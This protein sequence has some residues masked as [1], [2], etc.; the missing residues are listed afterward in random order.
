MRNSQEATMRTER[1]RGFM[2]AVAMTIATAAGARA[3]TDVEGS[4]AQTASD[5]PRAVRV[6][7]EGLREHAA[8]PGL[9]IAVDVG[10]RVAFSEAFGVADLETRAPATVGTR[11]RIGSVGKSLTAAGSLMLAERGRLDLDAPVNRYVPDAGAAG[12]ATARQLAGHLAGVRHYRRDDFLVTAHY[13][14]VMD[15][16]ALF[17]ADSLV[18]PPGTEYAYSTHGYTLLSAVMQA[19]AGEP[20]LAWME[21]E[22]FAPLGMRATGPDEVTAVVPWRAAFYRI[23]EGVVVPARVTDNSYKWAGGGFLSTAEDLAQFGSA[24]LDGTLLGAGVAE[25]LFA[26]QETAAG[27]ETGYGM[28]FRP[29]SDWEGRRVVHHGGSSEGGRAF[30]L[31]YPDEKVVVALAANRENAPLFEQESQ[32]IAHFFL[33]HDGGVL[34]DS[35]SGSWRFEAEHGED[36]VAG[37]LRLHAQGSI[38][39]MLDWSTAQAPIEILLVDRHAERL[40]LLGVG[41]HGLMNAWL[42]PDEDGWSG[43]WDY[44]GKG[45]DVRLERTGS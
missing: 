11:F 20:F 2:M 43:R 5:A 31:L 44:L 7:A 39:G 1:I 10:G 30:L 33:D 25:R 40:R 37:E 23:E 19:A 28:G 21:R 27:E 6:I 42:A 4:P 26:S 16:L 38:R 32:T 35:L 18:A 9:A 34:D 13:D 14:D 29:R 3:Q 12:A 15:A 24:L 45:G 41:P 8:L 17:V 36:A 22:V